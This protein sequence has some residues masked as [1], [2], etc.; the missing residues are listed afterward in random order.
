MITRIQLRRGLSSEWEAE[1]PTLAEGELGVETDTGK[2]KI[3]N[4]TDPWDDL[5]YGGAGGIES[6]A[7]STERDTEIPTPEH[8]DFVFLRDTNTTQFYDGVE[9]QALSAAKGGGSDKVFL[10]HEFTVNNSYTITSNHNV[11]SAGPIIVE[12]GAIITVPDGTNWVVV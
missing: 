4:G 3:G 11:I 12:D 9:W 6:F 7:D 1:N 10:E 5:P 2:F 8:G